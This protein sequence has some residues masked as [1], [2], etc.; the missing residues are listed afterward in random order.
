M[1][2]FLVLFEEHS[3][4]DD[5]NVKVSL[6]LHKYSCIKDGERENNEWYNVFILYH[7]FAAMV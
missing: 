5:L 6:K 7:W 2:I 4:R 1:Y 3:W